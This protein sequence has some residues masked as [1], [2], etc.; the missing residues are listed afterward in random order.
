MRHVTTILNEKEE[1]GHKWD[2][3]DDALSKA[4]L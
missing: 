3:Y 2:G 1:E 4:E